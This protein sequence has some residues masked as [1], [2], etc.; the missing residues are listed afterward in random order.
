[1][2]KIGEVSNHLKK[3]PEE[4]QIKPRKVKTGKKR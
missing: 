4:K 3:L 2:M 1:M